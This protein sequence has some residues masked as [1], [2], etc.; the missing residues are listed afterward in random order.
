MRHATW[1]LVGQ[2]QVVDWL[3][4]STSGFIDARWCDFF[5]P[6]KYAAPDRAKKRAERYVVAVQLL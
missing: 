5:F 1:L 6:W 3:L 4:V 2:T